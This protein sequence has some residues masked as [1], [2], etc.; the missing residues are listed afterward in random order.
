MSEY[1]IKTINGKQHPEHRLTVEEYLGVTLTKDQV[2]HHINGDKR[3]NRLE[4]LQVMSRAE[5]TG[6]HAKGSY[7]SPEKLQKLSAA[8]KGHGYPQFRKLTKEQ[9]T[10]I[11]RAMADGQSLLSLAKQY[12]VSWKLLNNIRQGATYQDWLAELPPDLFPLPDSGQKKKKSTPA[13]NRKLDVSQVTDIRLCI[14]SG[15]SDH[16]IGK[17]HGITPTTVARI[18][19]NETYQDIPWPKAVAEYQDVLDMKTLADRMLE[20]PIPDVDDGFPLEKGELLIL[21]GEAI[22]DR[23]REDYALYPNLHSRLAYVLLRKALA[24]DAV[25][26]FTLFSVSSYSETIP[27]LIA[28]E[29]YAAMLMLPD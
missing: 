25:S 3:D 27:Q 16:A 6:L 14:L 19:K 9:F 28:R 5:H 20:G 4:N 2:I 12:G 24:G 11:V 21:T 7:Q 15:M 18:R 17:R 1:K 13:F 8:K 26:L 10:E 29:S 23:L 22:D